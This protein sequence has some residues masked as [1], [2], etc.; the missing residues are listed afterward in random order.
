MPTRLNPEQM[1]DLSR[2]CN[3]A[4]KAAMQCRHAL[5]DGNTARA[6]HLA[7]ALWA[8]SQWL[9]QNMRELADREKQEATLVPPVATRYLCNV[10]GCVHELG[11][12][13]RCCDA[14]G[15]DPRG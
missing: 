2:T 3:A 6:L 4:T 11:H 9:L 14:E 15:A 5:L 8:D 13:G 10:P 12:T 7:K 1:R